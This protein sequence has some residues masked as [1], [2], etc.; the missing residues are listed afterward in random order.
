MTTRGG[1]NAGGKVP[2][3]RD[4]T[5]G[6]VNAGGPYPGSGDGK[7]PALSMRVSIG[8]RILAS[9]VAIVAVVGATTFALLDRT[10]GEDLTGELDARLLAQTDGVVKWLETAGHPE[11]LATRLSGVVGARV[12]IVDADGMVLGDSD[13]WADLGRPIGDAPEVA[14]ARGGRIGRATR[15]LV[16]EAAPAYLVAVPTKDGRVVRLAVPTARLAATRRE[17]RLRLL[18]ATAVGMAVA[19]ALGLVAS[20]AI[21]RPLRDM[22]RAAERVT[23]GDYAIG[24]PSARADELGVLSRALVGLADEVG[25]Q[26]AALTGE[27]DLSLAVIGAMVE[28]VIVVDDAG[29]R[30]VVNPAAESLCGAAIPD[31][32]AGHLDR[33]RAGHASDGEITLRDRVVLVSARPLP[34]TRGAVAVMHDVTRLRALEAVRRDFLA[35]AAHEL[36]TPVTAIA[37]FAETLADDAIAPAARAEFVATIRRNAV[38]IARVVTGLLELERLEARVEATTAPDAIALAP[39]V[40]AAV[41]A[42]AAARPDAPPIEVAI[43]AGL[44]VKGD[45]DGLDHVVQ[46]LIDNALLHG[47]PPVRVHAEA[48]A[49]KVRLTVADAGSGIAAPHQARVFDRFY[50]VAG[51]AR[52]GSGLGLAIARSHAQAMG[53]DLTVTSQVGQGATFML[54]LEQA[55]PGVA[56]GT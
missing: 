16:A 55:A 47:A 48:V 33:A 41:R 5:R 30:V 35:D 27:R 23:R 22:T 53:G 50:R 14:A 56:Q 7:V 37:G 29:A 28:G 13:Q 19:I 46:N 40:E 26:V 38:R 11:R 4:A 44:T 12:T 39:V 2:A 45:R 9:F 20:R 18:L 42:A 17:L 3:P 21:A 31:R 24:P 54:E 51:S 34:E 8:T 43:G 49:G 15:R 36:R 25:R 52:V 6:G 32:L 10:L 1:V